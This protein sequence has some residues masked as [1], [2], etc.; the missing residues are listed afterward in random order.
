LRT[1]KPRA[2]SLSTLNRKK[3]PLSKSS[4]TIKHGGDTTAQLRAIGKVKRK[5]GWMEDWGEQA[6]IPSHLTNPDLLPLF[7]SN[8]SNSPTKTTKRF[9]AIC[10][11]YNKNRA[12]EIRKEEVKDVELIKLGNFGCVG[13]DKDNSPI[14]ILFPA[15]V[16]PHHQSQHDLLQCFMY[17]CE[18]AVETCTQ[19]MVLQYN[20]LID[21]CGWDVR[22]N[23][24]WSC[25]KKMIKI[26]HYY[27]ERLKRVIVIGM[28]KGAR[29]L[30]RAHSVFQEKA[31]FTPH[32]RLFFA[33]RNQVAMGH[34]L[35]FFSK[36]QLPGCYC[37]TADTQTFSQE[38]LQ[39]MES[40]ENEMKRLSSPPIEES[41]K[42]KIERS[43]SF[44]VFMNQSS[45]VQKNRQCGNA[46]TL[47]RL[48]SRREELIKQI[49]SDFPARTPSSSKLKKSPTSPRRKPSSPRTTNK[50]DE[51][52]TSYK[53]KRLFWEQMLKTSPS[54]ADVPK[55]DKKSLKTE[56]TE[57]TAK[58]G[59]KKKKKGLKRGGTWDPSCRPLSQSAPDL[60]PYNHF[61]THS[62][63]SNDLPTRKNPFPTKLS[64]NQ[65]T[66][67]QPTNTPQE[68][69]E[70]DKDVEKASLKQKRREKR[71]SKR[72]SERT[73]QAVELF[74]QEV[75]DKYLG[76]YSPTTPTPL[77][78]SNGTRPFRA[79]L[80]NSSPT[81]KK[82]N[83]LQ[84]LKERVEETKEKEGKYG[85]KK[86]HSVGSNITLLSPSHFPPSSPPLSNLPLHPLLLQNSTES[87][88]QIE[89]TA[90][91]SE[92]GLDR[93]RKKSN[94]KEKRLSK[95][96]GNLD[97]EDYA[98][99]AE[100]KV[101][102]RSSSL[103]GEWEKKTKRVFTK[104]YSAVDRSSSYSSY[105]FNIRRLTSKSKKTSSKDKN[106]KEKLP[107]TLDS[108]DLPSLRTHSQND[109]DQLPQQYNPQLEQPPTNFKD[110][111]KRKS[112]IYKYNDKEQPE[113]QH[114]TGSHK[115]KRTTKIKS[116]REN[117][118]RLDTITRIQITNSVFKNQEKKND[119]TK[120]FAWELNLE[121][122]QVEEGIIGEGGMG[123]VTKASWRGLEVAVKK[124][125]TSGKSITPEELR[126]FLHEIDIMSK[127]RHP[128]IVLFLGAC[129]KYPDIC[130]V[131]EFVHQGDLHQFLKKNPKLP[132][133]NRLNA[134]IDT[135]RGMTFLHLSDP[136]YLHRDLKSY[137]LLVDITGKVK[138]ADFGISSVLEDNLGIE[139][140]FGTLNW[141]APEILDNNPPTTKSDIYSFA[142]V[143]W[144]VAT[145]KLPYEGMTE[146]Q[147]L[148][149]IMEEERPLIPDY[150]PDSYADLTRHCWNNQPS[151]RPEFFVVLE[152]LQKIKKE[153][154]ESETAMMEEKTKREGVRSASQS[155]KLS[156]SLS[157]P[158]LH[159]NRL[160]L[161]PSFSLPDRIMY[162][163]KEEERKE[164]GSWVEN[165][166]GEVTV[167]VD[168]KI[169]HC[170]HLAL[171]LFGYSHHH[172]INSDFFQLLLP[173]HKLKC[174]KAFTA[175]FQLDSGDDGDSKYRRSGGWE[176]GPGLVDNPPNLL[177]TQSCVA[178]KPPPQCPFYQK[179]NIAAGRESLIWDPQESSEWK[180]RM[181][182][183]NTTT[184]HRQPFDGHWVEV[185]ALHKL[186]HQLDLEMKVAFLHQNHQLFVTAVFLPKNRTILKIC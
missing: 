5:V 36:K 77:H 9:Q 152:R 99:T 116:K 10:E 13:R 32:S 70:Q 69:Q 71:R 159:L 112:Q 113:E 42:S 172:L 183:L 35:Q 51:D 184:S 134:V 1:I 151:K 40:G 137:N 72:V 155:P 17:L 150:V 127:L 166:F 142:M 148:Y 109:L 123:S 16:Y 76:G 147:I 24:E 108:L 88:E 121:E 171:Q 107:Q 85:L 46:E 25:L 164:K 126:N 80:V 34:L 62:L 141:V 146:I 86:G 106:K 49:E 87:M 128:N 104:S 8:N 31:N 63:S 144:E 117:L 170:S 21:F 161:R 168:G 43:K 156:K 182:Y 110:I 26:M 129:L 4:Q 53:E 14:F 136:P 119:E 115:K 45:S 38:I 18:Y 89:V 120:Q 50:T 83:S 145:G 138:V 15:L 125:R 103:I 66:S 160:L 158:N 20:L 143:L 102:G 165:Y 81:L 39:L 176:P 132:W 27:H 96:V 101:R 52:K 186:G 30:F 6:L 60:P 41:Q 11:W 7:L 169:V 181:M 175:F 111:G 180:S 131:T 153:H 167:N 133:I 163:G 59:G 37:G 54:K 64:V 135:A 56:S 82:T 68:N 93:E 22:Q 130:L 157:L 2:N 55:K 94:T 162:A 95:S 57:Q 84:H 28:S 98:K 61:L 97:C 174:A 114:S 177:K 47:R 29:S 92:M 23:W 118:T 19:N 73:K 139:G 65:P 149:A 44:R 154:I 122:M 178:F 90:M 124:M 3:K 33:N 48:K 105:P 79:T 140:G 185:Q 67:Q 58:G 179:P 75:E 91:S 173:Q 78:S 100:V 12:H 74:K